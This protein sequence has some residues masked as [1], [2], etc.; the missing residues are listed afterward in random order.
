MSEKT[1]RSKS[2][3]RSRPVPRGRKPQR[4]GSTDFQKTSVEKSQDGSPDPDP[5]DPET[6]FPNYRFGPGRR[7]VGIVLWLSNLLAFTFLTIVAL[8]PPGQMDGG[9]AILKSGEE[10]VGPL[11]GSWHR[12]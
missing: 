2:R 10:F 4:A 11:R 7:S 5:P 12:P 3:S 6:I 9:I 8:S 1:S